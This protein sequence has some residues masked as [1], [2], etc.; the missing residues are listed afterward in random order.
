MR[1]V[2]AR[3][4]PGAGLIL[5]G[6]A[7]SQTLP[8]APVAPKEKTVA[9]AEKLRKELD[10]IIDFE[11]A[12]QPLHLALN[13]LREQTKINFVLD[14]QTL[15]QMGIDPDQTPVQVK[16]K[17]TKVKTVLR[18]MLGAHNL[19]YGI[20]GDIIFIS[21]DE[22]TMFRQMQQRVTVDL[23]KLEFASALRQL[24]RETATNLIIDS[25]VV[26]EANQVVSLQAE[27]VPLETA[28]RLMAE[29][30]GLKPVRVGNV[31][32]VC[33]KTNAQEL[34][35][36]PEL[37]SRPVPNPNP[38]PIGEIAVPPMLVAP[39]RPVVAPGPPPPP[40]LGPADKPPSDEKGKDTPPPKPQ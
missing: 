36:D 19:S 39:G 35:A 26:K 40:Q 33:S 37:V 24:S 34:R 16:L 17:E 31:L 18:T 23:E 5:F 38:N 7:I 2:S 12:D 13:Q 30:V 8:A 15:A 28:V 29:M 10:R 25:R 21:T 6:L 3:F 9:P 27:D 14:R 20:V 1:L 32:F 4:W 11:A 22:M